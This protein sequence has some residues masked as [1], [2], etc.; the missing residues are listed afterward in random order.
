MTLPYLD[1]FDVG[2]FDLR[3]F[4]HVHGSNDPAADST[5]PFPAAAHPGLSLK[6]PTD[7]ESVAGSTFTYLK[8]GFDG[9]A[10][11]SVGIQF[12]YHG[13]SIIGA[14]PVL[15]SLYGDSSVDAEVQVALRSDGTL[16]LKAGGSTLDTGLAG[17]VHPDTWYFIELSADTA[18]T[19]SVNLNE[20][21]HLSGSWSS[22]VALFDAVGLNDT[23]SSPSG[24]LQPDL[25]YDDFYLA[26][27]SAWGMGRVQT[28]LP[29]GAGADT[30]LTPHPGAPNYG[31]VNDVPWSA[32]DYNSGTVIGDRDLYT[33]EDLDSATAEVKAIQ[34]VIIAAAT[35][36][37]AHIKAALRSGGTIYYD[38][39]VALDA[40]PTTASIA[41][42]EADPAT[43]TDWTPAGVNALQAG[44]EI[45]S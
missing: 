4:V 29:D 12:R 28:L 17:A 36:A 45:A 1:G 39:S 42:R 15:L 25:F 34:T 14:S 18:G 10:A 35:D 32:T 9:A 16:L 21:P 30:D 27:G 41:S 23:E 43:S 5:V 44:V 38:P 8:R 31:N 11:V 37:T 26:V 20:A 6:I 7:T 3:W 24:N 2:D 19:A 22:G 40:T 13:S 33:L